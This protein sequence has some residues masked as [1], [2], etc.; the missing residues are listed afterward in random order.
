MMI[1]DGKAGRDEQTAGG[2]PATD[3]QLAGM[4]YHEQLVSTEGQIRDAKGRV[5]F[6]KNTKRGR[7]REAEGGAMEVDEPGRPQKAKKQRQQKEAIGG[8]YRNKVSPAYLPAFHCGKRALTTPVPCCS[9]LAETSRRLARPTRSPT[10]PSV[11]ARARRRG[12]R[13]RSTSRARPRVARSDLAL[14]APPPSAL[15]S[16]LRLDD[17]C[18][19]RSP[20]PLVFCCGGRRA[21]WRARRSSSIALLSPRPPGGLARPPAQLAENPLTFNTFLTDPHHTCQVRRFSGAQRPARRRG[22]PLLAVGEL[23]GWVGR[24]VPVLAPLSAHPPAACLENDLRPAL[25]DL[26]ARLPRLLGPACSRTSPS[27]ARPA[28]I[29]AARLPRLG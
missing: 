19:P 25:A 17:N 6:N 1:D 29:T 8:E 26:P 21:C 18:M 27:R 11:R 20:L 10:F 23:R 9:L 5:I 22:P 12:A 14:F 3:E 2:G 24:S 28:S 13:A 7:A 15:F 4:A 16:L